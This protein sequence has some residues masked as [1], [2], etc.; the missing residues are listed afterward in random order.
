LVPDLRP[1]QLPG[2]VA[3]VHV[4][5]VDAAPPPVGPVYGRAMTGACPRSMRQFVGDRK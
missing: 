5:P 1:V 3:G 4:E 2:D